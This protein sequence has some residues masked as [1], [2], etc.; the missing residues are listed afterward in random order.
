MP[1]YSIESLT[2]FYRVTCL[3]EIPFD[4]NEKLIHIKLIKIV[5]M[6]NILT[7]ARGRKTVGIKTHCKS[8]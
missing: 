1:I 7:N 5:D 4:M 3:F 6:K 8:S 2:S